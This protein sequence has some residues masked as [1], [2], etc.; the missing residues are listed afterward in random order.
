MTSN[1][2]NFSHQCCYANTTPGSCELCHVFPF[3]TAWVKPLHWAQG[4]V[5]IKATC[6]QPSQGQLL[7]LLVQGISKTGIIGSFSAF[8]G[9]CPA[10]S[11]PELYKLLKIHLTAHPLLTTQASPRAIIFFYSSC[12]DSNFIIFLPEFII[13]IMKQLPIWKRK[14]KQKDG[15]NLKLIYAKYT[16]AVFS[17]YSISKYL[18]RE[19]K[20]HIRLSDAFPFLGK[21]SEELFVQNLFKHFR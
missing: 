21:L 8:R 5:V 15:L 11:L 6:K 18:S 12:N 7:A 9:S 4:R 19:K 20:N 16:L 1:C 10:L 13:L 3:V 17:N 2:K 14:R